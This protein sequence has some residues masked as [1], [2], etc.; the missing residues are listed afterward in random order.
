MQ[1]NL[2]QLNGTFARAQSTNGQ[3]F[4]A[5]ATLL[6]QCPGNAGDGDL[7]RAVGVV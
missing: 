6:N 1:H 2:E 7:E 3:G 5:I 4:W